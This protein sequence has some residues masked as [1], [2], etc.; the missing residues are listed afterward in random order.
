MVD[1]QDLDRGV[2]DSQQQASAS[3]SK[4]PRK[5][6]AASPEKAAAPRVTPV[7]IK[8]EATSKKIMLCQVNDAKLSFS[9]DSGAVGRLTV[10][11][12][13]LKID[14]KGRQYDGVIKAGP[15]VMLLNLAPPVA[16]SKVDKDGNKNAGVVPARAEMITNEFVEL[17]FTRDTLSGLMGAFSGPAA[18]DSAADGLSVDGESEDGD[19]A[20]GNGKKRKGGGV[21]ISQVTNKKR[22]TAAKGGRKKIKK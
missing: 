16:V 10:D 5:S 7:T 14:L 6:R 4:S 19:Q 3:P 17:T 21:V 9:G 15:T 18:A 13:A 20:G 12:E 22:K 1:S 2:E 8:K 11:S